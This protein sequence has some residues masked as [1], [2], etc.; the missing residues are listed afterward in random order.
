M[1]GAVVRLGPLAEGHRLGRVGES[2]QMVN[3]REG[4]SGPWATQAGW[5]FGDQVLSSGTN[6]MALLVVARAGGAAYLG[7]VGMATVPCMVMLVLLR[8]A[9]TQPYLIAAARVTERRQRLVAQMMAGATVAFALVASVF[10]LLAG[11]VIGSDTETGGATMVVALVLPAV[12]TQDFARYVAIGERCPQWAF[13]ADFSW[14][15]VQAGL[16]VLLV[17]HGRLTA[18]TSLLAWGAGASVGAL[19]GYGRF[20]LRP[21]PWQGAQDW[22]R[23]QRHLGGWLMTAQ[24]TAVAG[25]QLLLLSI[26]VTLGRAATGG[27]LG[28]LTLMRPIGVVLMAVEVQAFAL[29]ARRAAVRGGRGV[30]SVGL[31][32]AGAAI[33]VTLGYGLA[34]LFRSEQILVTVFGP[35]FAE[36]SDLLPPV[37]VGL[38]AIAPTL[39][40]MM[41]LRVVGKPRA[42]ATSQFVFEITR[43]GLLV[44]GIMFA[45][46][47]A[48]LWGVALASGVFTVVTWVWFNRTNQRG[49]EQHAS[50]ADLRMVKASEASVHVASSAADDPAAQRGVAQGRPGRWRS[51]TADRSATAASGQA[52][53]VRSRT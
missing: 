31:W 2:T 34:I 17:S 38:V 13:F 30:R 24:A 42:V 26:T 51:Q 8:S 14:A 11:V 47:V 40:S 22:W 28:V 36:Y 10:L 33:G 21:L 53:V 52:D 39:G 32:T 6:M 46:L 45:G 27:Y 29:M 37:V 1:A 35:S 9:V 7:S 15:A 16:L 48:G 25:Q 44:A 41:G 3:E 50:M 43:N 20:R 4:R 23:S 12:L 49:D 18:A 5:I 19:V